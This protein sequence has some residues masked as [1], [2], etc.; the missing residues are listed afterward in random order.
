MRR[1]K[2]QEFGLPILLD[3][4]SSSGASLSPPK[5]LLETNEFP[6]HSTTLLLCTREQLREERAVHGLKRL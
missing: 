3:K 5:A 6:T 1:E 4:G 2:A